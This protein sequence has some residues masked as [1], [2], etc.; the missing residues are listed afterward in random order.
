[1]RGDQ[2]G[3]GFAVADLVASWSPNFV[4]TVGD[5]NY[6]EGRAATIDVNIGKYYAAFIGD[7]TGQFGPGSADNRFWPTLGNHDWKTGNVDAYQAYFTLPGNERYYEIDHGLVHLFMVDS[8][9]EEPDGATFD[10]VQSMCGISSRASCPSRRSFSIRTG[11]H[12][13]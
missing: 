1:M 3:F 6:P 11:G 7:Y 10:S 2:Y 13:W 5:N 12:N 4:A 8:E 9:G